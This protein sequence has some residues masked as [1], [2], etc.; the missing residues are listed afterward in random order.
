MKNRIMFGGLLAAAALLWGTGQNYAQYVPPPQLVQGVDYG[1]PNYANSPVLTKF[2]NGLPGLTPAGRNNIGQY[3][4]VAVPMGTATPAGVPLDG[5]YYEIAIVDFFE[6]MHSDMPPTKLRGYVQIEPPGAAQPTG[7]LHVQLF[8]ADGVTPITF[9]G[10]LVYAY[11]KPHYLGPVIVANRGVPTRIKFYN[12]LATSANGGDLFIPV[13]ATLTGAGPGPKQIATDPV[14]K[15][16]IYENFTQ[17]RAVIHLHGGDNPWVSDGTLHQWITPAGETTSYPKGAS[18][19]SVSDMPLPANGTTTLYFPNGLSGRLLF[20]HEHAQ[21]ITRLGPY[22]GVAAG[23]LLVDPTE[24]ALNSFAPGGEIPLVIQDRT[25][26]SDGTL[27]VGFP[28]GAI[29]PAPTLA[30]DP[31]WALDS[32]WGQ[33]KGSLWFPH[34]YMPNQNPNDLSGANPMGRWDYGPWFWPVFPVVGPLPQTA[35]GP[36]PSVVPEAFMDTPIVNGTAYPVLNVNPTTYRFRILSVGNE[37]FF[38][39]QMY[40]AEPL[41]ISVVN[42]GSGY[43]ATPTITITDPTGTGASATAT[44]LGGVITGITVNNYGNANY[45]APTVTITDTT[46]TGASAYASVNT[47]V[48]MIPAAKNNGIAQGALDATAPLSGAVPAPVP[49]PAQWMANDTPGMTPNVLDNRIGGVPDPSPSL[50]GPV[51][52]HIGTEG[53]L[54]PQATV[55]P[56]TPIGYE[57]NKR[58][59]TVLNTFEHT[60]FLGPAE[61]ADVMVDFSA[62]AGKTIILYNDAPAPVPAGDPR[63]DYYTGDPDNTSQGGAPTTIAGFGPNT[64]TIMQIK[65]GPATVPPGGLPIGSISVTAAGTG[66]SAPAVTISDTAPGTGSGATASATVS[67]GMVTGVTLTA[68][69]MGY[70]A[71]VQ[72]IFTDPTNPSASGATG[73]AVLE[74]FGGIIGVTITNPG[75]GYTAATTVSFVGNGGTGSGAIATV[76]VVPPGAITGVTVLTPGSGYTAP[77]VTFTDA[78]GSGAAAVA[79]LSLPALDQAALSSAVSAAFASTQPKPIVP[80]TAYNAAEGAPPSGAD[81]FALISDTSLTFSP[82]VG[83]PEYTG[84][85]ITIPLLPKTIQELFDPLGRM[86]STLGVEIPFTTAVIQTTLPMGVEDPPTEVI[87]DGATQLWKVTHNGVDTHAIHF[88]LFD[89]Q[90]VNRVGWDGAIK[91]PWPEEVGWK[92]TV[93]MNPLEDIIVALR[94]RVPQVPFKQPNSVRPLSPANPLNARVN[95]Y[96]APIFAGFDPNNNPVTISN[97]VANFGHEYVWHCHLLGHEENDMMRAVCVATQPDPVTSL[98]QVVSKGKLILTWADPSP[99]ETSFLVQKKVG[100]GPWVNLASVPANTLTYTDGTYKNNQAAQYRVIAVNTVGSG[101][102]GYPNVTMNSLGVTV[103]SPTVPLGVVTISSVTQA[104]AVGS[105]AVVKWTYSAV[106]QTSFTIQWSTSSNFSQNTTSSATVAG[107]VFTYSAAITGL[108]RS[109]L[110]YFRVTAANA[111]GSGTPSATS[112]L[113]VHP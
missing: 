111:N 93:K 97:I 100:T 9:N 68:D 3:L 54:S 27:P 76:N 62:F 112:S 30:V 41:S 15:K 80:E 34:V 71:P 102:P 57:Q 90:V 31:T 49:W 20:Y 66:Y 8:Y 45:T 37:R 6:Q 39:L 99:D 19:Q 69:G 17:N 29:A 16:P 13:D 79:N 43:S 18:E 64:R 98:T 1:L 51:F 110:Y 78:T 85:P 95:Y 113:L 59:I 52:V 2:V 103:N 38:N 67:A 65:V 58:S 88:H 63:N 81:K 101:V 91:P 7:S 28:A 42:G 106:D 96:G 10:S 53:G 73:T 35:T 12:L 55:L 77:V 84:S 40:V 46:G 82:Y 61:R 14:T 87:P 32:R 23:Y 4:P 25:Y 11:D 105:P 74:P 89:V 104:A 36:L 21:G 94:A 22:V 109:T 83:S 50:Q 33:T 70:Q 26:V 44:V 86:N 107:N 60:L 56:N 48:R 24:R 5:D 108:R 72:V 75:T 92:D 47:E